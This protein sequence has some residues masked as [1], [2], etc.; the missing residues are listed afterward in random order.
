MKTVQRLADRCEPVDPFLGFHEPSAE[1]HDEGL[2]GVGR[3]WLVSFPAF[4]RSRFGDGVGEKRDSVGV[5]AEF[6]LPDAV[7]ERMTHAK[8]PIEKVCRGLQFEFK[9]RPIGVDDTDPSFGVVQV[10]EDGQPP[11]VVIDLGPWRIVASNLLENPP[12]RLD[13]AQAGLFAGKETRRVLC[14]MF[15]K[16]K[17][18]RVDAPPRIVGIMMFQNALD[19]AKGFKKCKN[20]RNPRVAH[21]RAIPCFKG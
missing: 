7:D 1:S 4:E 2:R 3:G 12:S 6:G 18:S 13:V 14:G 5:K 21:V 19:P 15:E 17:E 20:M 10:S 16:R 11:Q 8:H 9:G